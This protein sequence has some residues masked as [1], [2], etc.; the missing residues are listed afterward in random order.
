M[1]VSKSKRTKST[2]KP[3][4]NVISSKIEEIVNE[5]SKNIEAHVDDYGRKLGA[6]LPPDKIYHYTNDAGLRGI[7]ETGK[8]W[9][10]DIFNLNDPSELRY[11]M[12]PA[13][14]MMETAGAV[15]SPATRQFCTNVVAMLR[16]RIEDTANYFVC[17]FSHEPDD[18]GQW[19]AY[20]DNGRG[21]ALG[22]DAHM[23]EQ[24]FSKSLPGA[25]QT[26]PVN[27][28]DEPL[29]EIHRKIV[30][31]LIPMIDLPHE[32]WF[33][34]DAINDYMD[35]IAVNVCLPILRSGL[36][37]KHK[38]Y[39]NEQEYRF[40]QVLRSGATC[41][42]LK[43]RG[44]SHALI[45]YRE[46]DWRVHAPDSLKVIRL[47]PAANKD[48]AREFVKSCLRAFHTSVSPLDIDPSTIPYRAS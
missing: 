34:R 22:F 32:N 41:P 24:A 26:F 10:T 17:C 25:G 33:P 37:F 21:Y 36:F 18:L 2:K 28:K 40:M 38:A 46:F 31:D 13:I 14:E 23:L 8:I 1:P 48:T 11:G 29:Q 19:R 39:A 35:E 30:D 5:F 15:G 20:A 4:K 12:S 47:G 43:Y 27:Y 44:R 9:F 6:M 3:I 7:L 45:R 42:D 16:G